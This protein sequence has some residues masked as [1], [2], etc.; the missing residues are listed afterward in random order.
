MVALKKIPKWKRL[1]LFLAGRGNWLQAYHCQRGIFTEPEANA[2]A[3]FFGG[4]KPAPVDW[5]IHS[6]AEAGSEKVA[7]LE[8]SRYLRNQ[9]LR[10]SDVFSMAHGIELRVPFV[11]L[12]LLS[13]LNSIPSNVRYRPYKNLLLDSVPELPEWLKQNRKKGFAF[14]FEEWMRLGFGD[15][16]QEACQGVPVKP[17]TWYQTWA[18]AML[19]LRQTW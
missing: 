19:K 9:L 10:D 1:H 7:S 3:E 12:E 17:E 5:Q 11:D 13:A 4:I 8:A 18:V 15:M 16:L 6:L 14:P 2:L